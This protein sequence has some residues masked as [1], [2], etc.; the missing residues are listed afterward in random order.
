MK[1]T[2]I[3]ET[4]KVLG[5]TALGK[6]VFG[7]AVYQCVLT[8]RLTQEVGIRQ[9]I[10]LEPVSSFWE[11]SIQGTV[12]HHG[13]GEGISA[14]G[15]IVGGILRLYPERTDVAR[16]AAIWERWHLNGM[17]AGTREQAAALVGLL[18]GVDWYDMACARLESAGLLVDRGY[19][20]GS[21]WLVEPLPEAVLRE[22]CGLFGVDLAEMELEKG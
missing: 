6:E 11:L 8:L 1:P 19:K 17:K 9:T 14:A 12:T 10:D 3:I 7:R 2:K 22:I 4:S 5:P 13:K 15:Q 16:I 18:P 20:Y 21:K